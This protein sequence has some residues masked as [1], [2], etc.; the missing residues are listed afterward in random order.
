MQQLAF[1][2]QLLVKPDIIELRADV[3]FEQEDIK[4]MAHYLLSKIADSRLIEIVEG[5]D[6]AYFRADIQNQSF[7][8]NFEVYSQSCWLEPE[9]PKEQAVLH[10]I[11]SFL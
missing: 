7:T 8:I 11:T 3:D 4:P 5:V 10:H 2:Y 1:N 6:R 9:S